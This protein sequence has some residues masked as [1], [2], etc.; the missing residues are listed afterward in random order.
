MLWF[1]KTPK[2]K[3][4]E[5]KVCLN[6][7]SKYAAIVD[8]LKQKLK[9]FK[10]IIVICYFDET[11][12]I[13][14]KMLEELQIKYRLE[15]EYV[16]DLQIS[17]EPEIH[18][19]KAKTLNKIYN[20]KQNNLKEGKQAV[21]FLFVE[22]YPIYSKEEALLYKIDSLTTYNAVIL[23]F[24]SLDE[25]LLQVFGSDNIKV[26]MQR[27]GLTETECIEHSWVTKS[28]VN[29]QKKI[30]KKISSDNEAQSQDAWFKKNYIA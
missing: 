9:D 16:S 30:E 22:H 19:I 24:V 14:I 29:A 3:R 5:D 4:L 8:E 15:N 11:K 21:N 7:K 28:I 23:F 27:L 6:D 25:P 1:K 10:S 13:L 20:V 12:E 26:M 2:S 18:I 17:N